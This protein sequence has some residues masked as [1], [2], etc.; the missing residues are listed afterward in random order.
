[1]T[2]IQR[3]LHNRIRNGDQA[4]GM[5]IAL[6]IE[7]TLKY[8]DHVVVVNNEWSLPTDNGLDGLIGM[9][10]QNNHPVP[11]VKLRDGRTMAFFSGQLLKIE[12]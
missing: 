12:L 9:V 7:P 6:T 5:I 8:G 10:I 1:M 11:L 3:E 4:A 2:P